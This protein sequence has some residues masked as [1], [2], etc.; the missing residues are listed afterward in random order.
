MEISVL[1]NLMK[2][3]LSRVAFNDQTIS[4]CHMSRLPFRS[5]GS[6]WISEGIIYVR[7]SFKFLTWKIGPLS[8][9]NGFHVF[10]RDT[11]RKAFTF[12]HNPVFEHSDTLLLALH[13]CIILHINDKQF[14]CSV[15]TFV[16]YITY[17]DYWPETTSNDL[18]NSCILLINWVSLCPFYQQ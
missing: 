17:G 14:G 10:P 8:H 18:V 6:G 1:A 16:R 13:W 2:T 15:F 4:G 12:M 9:L 5:V 3:P 11:I 7:F